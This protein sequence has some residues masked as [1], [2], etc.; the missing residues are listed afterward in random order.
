MNIETL[1][2]SYAGLEVIKPSDELVSAIAD[3]QF[4]IS[5]EAQGFATGLIFSAAG[6][7][8]VSTVEEN[9]ALTKLA[10]DIKSYI[11]SVETSRK[12]VTDP[13]KAVADRIKR[14]AD[15]HVQELNEALN[16]L[17]ALST[18]WT[19]AERERAVRE[20][21]AR[22]A[23]LAKLQ[24]RQD[25]LKTNA[26][27]EKVEVKIQATIAAPLPEAVK[28]R[29]TISR[30][31]LK[32]E[33]TDIKALYAARPELCHVEPNAAAIKAVCSAKLEVPGLRLWEEETTS[34][35]A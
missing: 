23:E 11:R 26:A 24:A 17:S 34:F 21:Q 7:E 16:K 3:A 4:S 29:G 27:K 10:I 32:W 18:Q 30:K 22:A 33:V 20:E 5:T 25:A 31:V 14:T 9:A 19:R 12:S 1:K 2:N 6:F 35:R 8:S 15:D 13:I 28:A